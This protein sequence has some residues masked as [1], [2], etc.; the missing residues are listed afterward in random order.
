MII[1]YVIDIIDIYIYIY[2]N[3]TGANSSYHGV[4]NNK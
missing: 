1:K 3:N 2:D 4:N